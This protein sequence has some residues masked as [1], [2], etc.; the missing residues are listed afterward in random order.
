MRLA[1]P[2]PKA[3]LVGNLANATLD[4][5]VGCNATAQDDG[6]CR[7]WVNVTL[8]GATQA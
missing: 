2:Y 4:G 7:G 8:Q 3:M 1:T 5:L 6:R